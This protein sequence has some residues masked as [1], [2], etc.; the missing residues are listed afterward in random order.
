MIKLSVLSLFITFSLYVGFAR[1]HPSNFAS[2]PRQSSILPFFSSTIA[3]FFAYTGFQVITSFTDEVKGGPEVAA[4][5]VVVS[6]L[7]SVLFYVLVALSLILLVPVSK[8]GVNADPL[9]FALAYAGAP[10]WLHEVVDFGGMV[11]TTSATLA[12]ILAS[13]RTLYQLAL[14]MELPKFLLKYDS[15]RD[16][17]ST[18]VVISVAIAIATF[19][20]G[21]VYVIASISNFGLVFSFIAS[22]LALVH[23]RRRGVVG[24]Y[25]TPLYPYSIVASTVMLISLLAGFPREAL[26][27]NVAVVV[28]M[29]VAA[30]LIKDFRE[31]NVLRK[32]EEK[33]SAGAGKRR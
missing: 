19:F 13:G 1:F 24:T 32:F 4:R 25:R 15:Q 11:A 20:A 27:I 16:V 10:V 28:V 33:R 5:A 29:F 14:D 26:T 30:Y 6:V 31:L 22:N 21:N 12:M 18:A 9:S 23:F 8:F 17:P 2:T 7:I 3:I